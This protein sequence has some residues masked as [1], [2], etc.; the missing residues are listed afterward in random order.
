MDIE[1]LKTENE[2]NLIDYEYNFDLQNNAVSIKIDNYYYDIFKNITFSNDQKFIL[3]HLLF[4]LFKVIEDS[5]DNEIYNEDNF[6]R[7]Y[8]YTAIL[9]K[10]INQNK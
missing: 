4:E 10:L 3:N 7:A 5:R 1:D 2:L 8:E 6:V 9:K